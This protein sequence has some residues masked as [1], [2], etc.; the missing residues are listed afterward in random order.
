MTLREKVG[1]MVWPSVFGDF[2]AGDSPQWERVQG[3][4]RND[5]VGGFTIS[6]G[7]PIEIAQKLN[8]MQTM[9]GL[10]LLFGADFEYG[11]GFRAR[12]GYFVP[13]AIDLGGAVVFPPQMALGA[14]R[15]TGL[16][17][18]QGRVTAIEGRALGVHITYSPVLDVNNNPANP[19]INV[20]SYGA[21]A[22]LAAAMGRSFVRGVQEHGMAA[23]GKHFPGHGDT[24]VNSHLGLPVVTVSRQRL[25]SVEF[26]PFRAAVGVGLDAIMSFHGAMPALDS[27]GVPGTLSARV[28]GGVL[29]AE[30]GFRGVVISDAMDMRGVL[31]TYGA[32]RATRM[33]VAAGVDIL[34]QPLNVT[35]TIDAVIAGVG[36]G[37][38]TEARIDSSVL[39]ILALK[40]RFGLHRRR[41]I[42][43][44]S[45]RWLVGTAA[46]QEAA[47]LVAEK[48]ITLVRDEA[49]RVPLRRGESGSV[50]SITIARRADLS[51]GVAFNAELRRTLGTVRAEFVAAEDIATVDRTR[52]LSLADSAGSV[53]L[54]YYV[55][56]SWDSRNASAPAEF[57]ELVANLERRGRR[58]VLVS[59]GNPY[60][61]QQVPNTST[62]M[63]AW[64]G[65]PVSQTAAAAALAG[66][67]PIGGRLPITIP[68]LAG[69]GDGLER[70][71]R[72]D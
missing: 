10:P 64:G 68:P 1:Q 25:D 5:R 7:S 33:A 55:G 19:V 48:S 53:V 8:E 20:R 72:R 45:V 50:L 2:V 52:L 16:A 15:D 17:Y 51:A 59:F 34:I 67:K 54:G 24:D 18:E 62:Y 21:D 11:A 44:D 63:I 71:P 26:V 32:E 41:T 12:G 46:N 4:I 66:D 37:L 22:A 58:F 40:E 42:Q 35:Q 29:R 38:Y 36:E 6:V 9:S 56:Q 3:W 60:L 23:T 43:L 31:D 61:L 13:N 14:S 27:T 39:R 70:P 30:M 69:V 28:I 49:N 65:F 47:R 57:T